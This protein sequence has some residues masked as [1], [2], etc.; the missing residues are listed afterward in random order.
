M[1]V[2]E[3]L[4]DIVSLLETVEEPVEDIDPDFTRYF[5]VRSEKGTGIIGCIGLELF[6]GTALLRSFAVDPEY[7]GT[8]LGAN[9]VKRVIEEAF[10][11]GSETIYVCASKT[12]EFFWENE[13]KGIDL[14]DVPGEI[15]DSG[16]FRK[17]CPQVAA[18]VKK[19]VIWGQRPL[20]IWSRLI[21]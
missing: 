10:N 16:L 7:E 2:F 14:D 21:E 6:T 1:A 15:R 20:T 12:P 11:A 3:D 17:D 4:E 8:E 13:F 5:I 19:R 18:F 9:L